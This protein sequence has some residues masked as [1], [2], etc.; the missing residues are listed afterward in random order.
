MKSFQAHLVD[1]AAALKADG[2]DVE[3]AA[4]FV[5]DKN[6][7]CEAHVLVPAGRS[8][9]PF[10]RALAKHADLAAAELAKAVSETPNPN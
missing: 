7:E 6:G 10:L 2:Y 8:P 3:A 1:L 9:S 5:A 4:L